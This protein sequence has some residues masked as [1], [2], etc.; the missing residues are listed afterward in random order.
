MK[1]LM[2]ALLAALLL[3]TACQPTPEAAVVVQKDMDRMIDQAQE[4]PALTDAPKLSLKER[5]AIPDALS[6]SQTGA[7]GK[8]AVK[9][10]AVVTAP[11]VPFPIV[12]AEAAE[13]SQETVTAFW[14]AFIG[15]TPM[16][17]PNLVQTK[18]DIEQKILYLRQVQAGIIDG[19]YTSEEAQEE[20]DALEAAYPSAPD[21]VDMV[22]ATP[23]LKRISVDIGEHRNV[24]HYYGLQAE[25]GE[26]RLSFHVINHRDNK[27]PIELKDYDRKGNEAGST[28]LGVSRHARLQCLRM[29]DLGSRCLTAVN[30]NVGI[31]RV[32]RD[33]PLPEMASAF[34][35]LTPAEA[36][37]EA[38]AFLA[39]VGLG[40]VMAISD[41]YLINDRDEHNGRPEA[42]AFAYEIFFTRMIHGAPCANVINAHESSRTDISSRT[43]AP[44]WG[45]ERFNLLVDDTGIFDICWSAPV[46]LI[47]TVMESSALKPFGE[48]EEIAK[49]MLPIIYEPEARE[50]VVKSI[51]ISIDCISLGLWRVTEPDHFDRGL[52]IPVWNFFG[53]RSETAGMYFEFT[54]ISSGSMLTINAIDGS[55][56]DVELGY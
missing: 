36:A 45:Y 34:I 37:T 15:D 21:S 33:S 5:R 49:K 47:E 29:N 54:N 13:F 1:R 55:I 38:E 56:I 27:E 16:F 11:D 48:I 4:G 19:L 14:N 43:Y 22:P 25:N 7:N 17:E 32:E 40:E 8:L 12:R 53:T 52:Y 23:E 35:S 24:A 2:T 28:V 44:T 51:D 3:L 6:F 20:I 31:M 46:A 42:K 18:A 10:D 39:E 9:V 26:Q 50:E 41:I 30:N